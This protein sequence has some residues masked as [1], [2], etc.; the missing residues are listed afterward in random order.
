[1]QLPRGIRPGFSTIPVASL[2]N[3]A[4][5]ARSGGRFVG[6]TQSSSAMRRFPRMAVVAIKAINKETSYADILKK[7]KDGVSLSECGIE[8]SRV[9]EAANGGLIIEVH[10]TDRKDKADLLAKRLRS[11]LGEGAEVSRP[12]TTGE[13]RI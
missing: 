7:A 6:G 2:P 3:G 8:S 10:S 9:R 13:I 4:P 12:V 5:G 1:M 11:A